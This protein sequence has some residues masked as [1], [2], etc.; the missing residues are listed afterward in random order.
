MCPVQTVTHVSGRLLV[1]SEELATRAE[2][3]RREKFLKSGQGRSELRRILARL[4]AQLDRV[5]L[6]QRS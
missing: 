5:R 4:Q 1:H 3:M 2:A 6:R